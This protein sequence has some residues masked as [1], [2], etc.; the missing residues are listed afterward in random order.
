MSSF[1]GQTFAMAMLIDKGADVNSK[2]SIGSTPLHYATYRGHLHAAIL[3]LLCNSNVNPQD[4]KGVTPLQSASVGPTPDILAYLIYKNA[5]VDIQ[6][7]HGMTALHYAVKHNFVRNA[8]YL[9]EQGSNPDIKDKK[10]ISSRDLGKSSKNEDILEMFRFIEEEVNIFCVFNSL[11]LFKKN[12]FTP[13]AKSKLFLKLDERKGN[14]PAVSEQ[15]ERYEFQ[16]DP[17]AQI[18]TSRVQK[19]GPSPFAHLGFNFDVKYPN[20]KSIE[21]HLHFNKISD[22]VEIADVVEKETKRINRNNTFLNIMRHFLLIPSNT[23]VA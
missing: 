16:M 1:S 14:M 6:N 13:E 22:G 9:M 18:S 12:P 5:K 7:K 2:S 11:L 20:P 3:L 17:E 8:F 10:G 23:A 15:L 19:K 4:N 21:I